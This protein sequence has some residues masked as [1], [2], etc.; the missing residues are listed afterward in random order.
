M[1]KPSK[2]LRPRPSK[3]V[4]IEDGD[5]PQLSLHGKGKSKILLTIRAGGTP[6]IELVNANATRSI[7]LS[8][9]GEYAQIEILDQ[10]KP[11]FHVALND[12]GL[13]EQS[14]T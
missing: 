5:V 3:I 10:F 7:V 8:I 12:A 6:I 13:I 11:R 14:V 2:K 1:R 9:G 4:I